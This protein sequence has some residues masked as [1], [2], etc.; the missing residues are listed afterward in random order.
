MGHAQLHVEIGIGH[1]VAHLLIGAAGA[2][3]G[4]GGAEGNQSHGGHSRGH[5]HEIALGN[6]HIVVAVRVNLL[7][8]RGLG[9]VG[10]IRVQNHHLV[11]PRAQLNQRLAVRGAG[12]DFLCHLTFPPVPRGPPPAA[13]RWGPFRASP[14]DFP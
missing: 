6:A 10:Q 5:R 9:G 11:V 1:G 8:F 7:K 13:A 14:P 12:C 3:H 2:E 4:K